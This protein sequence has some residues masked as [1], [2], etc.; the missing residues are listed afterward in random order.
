MSKKLYVGNLS[1]STTTD[2]LKAAFQKA[3]N[4]EDAIVMT[5]RMTGR[6]RGFGF[7]TMSDDDAQKAIDMYNEKDLDGRAV[8]VNEA[9]PMDPNR[10]RTGGGNGGGGFRRDNMSF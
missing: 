4:V 5:D 9:K 10:P 7:V 3:G 1:Y 6:S 2:S 8:K